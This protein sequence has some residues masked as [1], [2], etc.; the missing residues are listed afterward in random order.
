MKSYSNDEHQYPEE[1]YLP[2]SDKWFS[3]T[4]NIYVFLLNLNI[5]NVIFLS[6][7]SN[8][9]VKCPDIIFCYFVK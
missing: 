2:F 5:L 9:W 3:Y 8:L 7:I 6:I 4:T 1:D